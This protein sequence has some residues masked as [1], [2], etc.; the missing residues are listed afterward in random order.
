[1]RTKVHQILSL[2]AAMVAVLVV[3]PSCIPKEEKEKGE[4]AKAPPPPPPPEPARSKL[5][6][7]PDVL[8]VLV[9]VE[10][11]KCVQI[12]GTGNL[13]GA[14]A[15]I[16]SCKSSTAQQ[17][18]LQPVAGNYHKLVSALSNKCLATDATSQ[19]TGLKVVQQTC[20]DG[21]NQ[22][23]I[24][25]DTAG[26]PGTLQIVARHN[27]KALDINEGKS[28]DGTHV[29]TWPAKVSGNQQFRLNPVSAARAPDTTG[30]AAKAGAGGSSEP[31]AAGS[32]GGSGKGAKG[33][34]PKPGSAKP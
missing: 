16:S 8:Y 27:G 26:A 23:W 5:K 19:D 11:N 28:D 20:G 9:A 6:I 21:T 4:A 3:V 25:A 22:Q 33:K 31:A 10:S 24:L 32:G 12:T 14:N 15:E 17:F 13:E 29:I 18:K 7:T 1:M 34:K 2:V 30:S